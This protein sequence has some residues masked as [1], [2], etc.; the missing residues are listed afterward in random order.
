M[1]VEH[2]PVLRTVRLV[3]RRVLPIPRATALGRLLTP[4]LTDRVTLRNRREVPWIRLAFLGH[5]TRRC[6]ALPTRLACPYRP[7]L[8][9]LGFTW[10]MLRWPSAFTRMLMVVGYF[11][12]KVVGLGC[13]VGDVG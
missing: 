13:V 10:I 2:P 5:P 3:V 1:D 4:L 9:S 8:C 11:T 6:A 12:V 7:S